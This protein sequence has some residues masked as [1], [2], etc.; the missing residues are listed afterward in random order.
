MKKNDNIFIP[1]EGNERIYEGFLKVAM[2]IAE[3]QSAENAEK[4][5]E[6]ISA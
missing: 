3:R 4:P 6:K 5:K 2:E 1:Y